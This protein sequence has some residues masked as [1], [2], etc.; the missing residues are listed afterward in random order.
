MTWRVRLAMT[1]LAILICFVA[2]EAGG[3]SLSIAGDG[4]FMIMAVLA[5]V[6]ALLSGFF[7][8]ADCIS[9]ERREGTFGLLYLTRLKSWDIIAG[10]LASS[11]LQAFFGLVAVLPVLF[12]PLLAG[13]I[14]G[15]DL[16]RMAV[17][18]LA[19]MALSLS[20]GTFA[21]ACSH[22]ARRSSGLTTLLV[23]APALAGLIGVLLA[24]LIFFL[25]ETHGKKLR[26][27]IFWFAGYGALVGW[28]M[29]MVALAE[30]AM[31]G[32]PG[33]AFNHALNGNMREFLAS[34]SAVA[35]TAIFYL[36]SAILSTEWHLGD[37]E[38][39]ADEQESEAARENVFLPGLEQGRSLNK[40]LG[41]NPARWL[42][43]R[44]QISR[45]PIYAAAALLLLMSLTHFAP[46][47]GLGF[48]HF[49]AFF[50]S[51]P[52]ALFFFVLARHSASPF[53]LLKR[54]GFLETV[55]TTPVRLEDLAQSQQSIYRRIL[56]VPLILL[57]LS[58]L[59]GL[60]RLL[61][62]SSF[63]Q[64]SDASFI[65]FAVSWLFGWAVFLFQFHVL[66]W[67]AM[68][69]GAEGKKPS[70]AAGRTLVIIFLAPGLVTSLT[71]AFVLWL[72]WF[73]SGPYAGYIPYFFGQWLVLAF[74]VFSL[75][76]AKGKMGVRAPVKL[77]SIIPARFHPKEES[78]QGERAHQKMI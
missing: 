48:G 22:S 71:S 8:T 12:V 50:G 70:H 24:T 60:Y 13:G 61:R 6:Y 59:T 1:G 29:W 45:A 34:V 49:M 52:T 62:H 77:W 42:L 39:S 35:G 54:S 4:A 32:S 37:R 57:L 23:L 16:T 43:D 11:S 56:A 74:F 25:F 10:K 36:A 27:Y 58:G 44:L 19:T 64:N 17:V 47:T 69:H 28:L 18:L 78:S 33:L 9:E 3:S 72:P 68:M 31:V 5:F 51:I 55:L 41:E 2:M 30:H 38:I 7:F 21:S 73:R 20:A 26:T 63:L 14:T 15:A 66:V 46:L 76:W 67:M 65:S 53:S 75:R 40:P